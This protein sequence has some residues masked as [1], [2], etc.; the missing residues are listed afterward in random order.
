MLAKFFKFAL[1]TSVVMVFAGCATGPTYDYTAFKKSSPRSILILPPVNESPDVKATYSMLSQMTFPLAESGYYVLPVALVD[2]TFKQNGLTVASD[3]QS[4]PTKKLRDIFGAD[5]A[6]YVTITQYGTTYAVI[7]SVTAVTAKAKL[8]DLK[9]AEVLWE[10]SAT[11][12]NNQN[13]NS[14]GGIAGM[15]ISAVVKQILNSTF[16]ASH[17]V[18]G[19]ASQ[20]LLSAGSVNG[21]LYGPYSQKYKSD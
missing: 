6:L 4:L 2:E 16:D 5:A 1:L 10:G 15:L 12:N 8:V 19:A 21:V 17:Q 20:R 7:D 9:T 13:N 11:A 18:A 3:I 14:G